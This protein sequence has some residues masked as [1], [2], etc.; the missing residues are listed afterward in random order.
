MSS[1]R[2]Y[3][4]VPPLWLCF[5]LELPCSRKSLWP[6]HY[7]LLFRTWSKFYARKYQCK[8]PTFW[9]G[10][11]HRYCSWT[12]FIFRCYKKGTRTYKT[13]EFWGYCWSSE[14]WKKIWQQLFSE[15][16]SIRNWRYP[17]SDFIY[18]LP[19]GNHVLTLEEHFLE[20]QDATALPIWRPEIFFEYPD[21][22]LQEQ[23]IL[24]LLELFRCC[25]M[26]KSGK[27]AVSVGKSEMRKTPK[28]LK[29]TVTNLVSLL[30][31]SDTST[32]IG[33]SIGFH[34]GSARTTIIVLCHI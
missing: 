30:S 12:I 25:L 34:P 7:Q 19:S 31:T 29:R 23:E 10:T 4:L 5:V 27:R 2:R 8:G 13:R 22:E 3:V 9:H 6:S 28:T 20:A 15:F 21:T 1:R 32:V 17:F 14:T 33:S 16:C 18:S 11:D 24:D 26:R